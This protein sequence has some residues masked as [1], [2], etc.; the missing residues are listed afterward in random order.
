MKSTNKMAQM[1]ESEPKNEATIRKRS[2]VGIAA[3][4]FFSNLNNAETRTV[5]AR[6]VK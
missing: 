5:R 3:E 2:A 4:Q 6:L 1:R